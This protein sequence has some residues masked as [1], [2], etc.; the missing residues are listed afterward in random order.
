MRHVIL[1]SSNIIILHFII[2]L[3]KSTWLILGKAFQIWLFI[4]FLNQVIDTAL[5]WWSNL[6]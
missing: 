4:I 6:C 5:V 3:Q 1:S 2:L